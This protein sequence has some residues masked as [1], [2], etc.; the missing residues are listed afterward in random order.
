MRTP[1]VYSDSTS[2]RRPFA[3]AGD[4]HGI[5]LLVRAPH[6]GLRCMGNLGTVKLSRI[7]PFCGRILLDQRLRINDLA[8]AAGGENAA[9]LLNLT[10]PP[11]ILASPKTGAPCGIRRT[12]AGGHFQRNHSL[13]E[14]VN[15]ERLADLIVS[16]LPRVL[17][18]CALASL[19]Q[20]SRVESLN[21]SI[22]NGQLLA[23]S[24]GLPFIKSVRN[25][26][27]AA[28][29]ECIPESRH[30]VDGFRPRID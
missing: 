10:V 3:I 29:S 8:V 7:Y 4:R 17:R 5:P 27:A 16:L 14:L 13:F 20:R 26:Q 22:R 19:G 6:R 18:Q 24:S 2:P 30:P 23:P 1:T 15:A 9:K 12:S 11:A 21:I 28:L 25:D